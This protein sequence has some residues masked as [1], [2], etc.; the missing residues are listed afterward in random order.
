M[1][2]AAY[3]I[4]VFTFSISVESVYL[5]NSLDNCSLRPFFILHC[6][7]QYCTDLDTTVCYLHDPVY[8]RTTISDMSSVIIVSVSTEALDLETSCAADK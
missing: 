6:S 1:F 2:R 7:I 8:S 5:S 3:T 4:P